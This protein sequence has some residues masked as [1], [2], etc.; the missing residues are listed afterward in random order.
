VPTVVL[1]QKP[2]RC[3]DHLSGVAVEAGCDLLVNQRFEFGIKVDGHRQHLLAPNPKP[4]A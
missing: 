3:P 4:Q 2:K 1:F